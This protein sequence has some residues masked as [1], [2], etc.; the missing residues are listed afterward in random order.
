MQM[1]ETGVR[2]GCGL[3]NVSLGQ[4][5]THTTVTPSKWV[6]ASGI[7]GVLD[8]TPNVSLHAPAGAADAGVPPNGYLLCAHQR[9]NSRSGRG[10]HGGQ[11]AKNPD[12]KATGGRAVSTARTAPSNVKTSHVSDLIRKSA[13]AA[14]LKLLGASLWATCVYIVVGQGDGGCRRVPALID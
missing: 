11:K 9:H 14:P 13:L 12:G 1:G 10:R 4:H 5:P 3:Q 8:I 6:A 7:E 2:W